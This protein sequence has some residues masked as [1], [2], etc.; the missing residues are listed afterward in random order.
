MDDSDVLDLVD[1]ALNALTVAVNS[2]GDEES[3]TAELLREAHEKTK[4]VRKRLIRRVQI[5]RG[6]VRQ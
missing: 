5:Q 1:D 4:D 2:L 3:M 6:E